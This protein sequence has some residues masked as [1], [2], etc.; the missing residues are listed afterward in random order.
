MNNKFIYLNIIRIN[1]I[2]KL[3]QF[4]HAIKKIKQNSLV[5]L[6]AFRNVPD[7]SNNLLQ[8]WINSIS[9]CYNSVKM[10]F[11][12]DYEP[13]LKS[14]DRHR[15]RYKCADQRD[16]PHQQNNDGIS[17]FHT[18]VRLRAVREMPALLCVIIFIN[19]TWFICA[20]V[21]VS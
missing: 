9:P 20:P 1:Y 16:K 13:A 4:V 15:I 14:Y 2:S 21:W 12:P 5:Y 17:Y 7:F 8:L 6:L 10:S 18:T 11:S 3:L 19:S